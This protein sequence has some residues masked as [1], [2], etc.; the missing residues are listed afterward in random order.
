MVDVHQLENGQI[1]ISQRKI[2][3]FWCILYKTADL[4]LDDSQWRNTN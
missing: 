3:W 1:V 2:I 4:E